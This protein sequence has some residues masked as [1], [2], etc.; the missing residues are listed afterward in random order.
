MEWSQ[1]V[2]QL[3]RVRPGPCPTDLR[4]N[5]MNITFSVRNDNPDTIWNKL[6]AKL[7]REPSKAEAI[8]EV[9]RI[10]REPPS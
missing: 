8:A 1:P 5:K 6:T 3:V 10:L 4:E 2:Q 7:G 9:Q